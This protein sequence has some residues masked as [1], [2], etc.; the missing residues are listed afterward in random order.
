MQLGY[1]WDTS[2]I[3]ILKIASR[4]YTR[5]GHPFLG[6]THHQLGYDERM[7]THLLARIEAMRDIASLQSGEYKTKYGIDVPEP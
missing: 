1:S 7:P 3:L 4:R 2:L 5:E 6:F